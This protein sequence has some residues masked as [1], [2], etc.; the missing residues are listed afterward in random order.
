[1]RRP[2]WLAAVLLLSAGC[3][4]GVPF[5]RAP[6]PAPNAGDWGQVREEASRRGDLYD[7]FVHRAKASATW[8]SPAVREVGARRLAEWQGKNA[9][10]TEQAVARAKADAALGEEFIVAF[11]S[12]ERRTNDLDAK[13]SVWHL[14]LD[15]GEVRVPASQVVALTTD[16]T[17]RQLFSYVDPFDVV[18]RVRFRWTGAPLQG[19]P[20]T[21]RIGGGL[22]AVVLDF[23]PN[24]ARPH[25]PRLAP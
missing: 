13:G 8:Y 23:G 14:E 15:D 24:G 4:S 19:R 16:A 12:A 17:I 5:R 22:G 21:L 1:M 6:T 3:G 2:A 7:G 20:F 11:F 9:E 18:Y 10:E 25:V